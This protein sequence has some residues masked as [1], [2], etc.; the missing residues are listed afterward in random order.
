M[1]AMSKKL[2]HGSTRVRARYKISLA[3]TVIRSW[4]LLQ[5]FRIGK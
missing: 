5:T 4:E 3:G 1:N 2:E